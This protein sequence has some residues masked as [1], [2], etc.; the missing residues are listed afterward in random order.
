MKKTVVVLGMHSSGTSMISGILHAIGIN[1]NPSPSGKV[2]H[3]KTN[4]D[5]DFFRLNVRILASLKG[6][7]LDPPT[8]DQI[9]GT[10][11][12]RE[13]KVLITNRNKDDLWGFKDPRT[14]ITAPLYHSHLRSPYY[15]LVLRRHEDIAKSIMRR[16]GKEDAQRWI[17]LSQEYYRQAETFLSSIDTPVLRV[18][19]EN[20][21]VKGISAEGVI[22]RIIKFV[23]LTDTETATAT[24]MNTILDRGAT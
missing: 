13:I 11:F 10:R 23:G 18:H 15:I 16:G 8:K 17:V 24:A 6:G 19:S 2:R 3:Y 7:W 4:E 14:C 20:L 22:R 12:E 1:M 21:F 5:V 9:K